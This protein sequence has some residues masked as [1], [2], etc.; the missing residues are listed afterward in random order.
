MMPPPETAA[1]RASQPADLPPR[2]ELA[3]VPFF[4][5]TPYQCGPAALATVLRSAGFDATPEQLAESVFLPSREG[6]LQTEMLAGARRSGAWALRLPPQLADV[7]REVQRGTP[8]IVLQNLGLSFAPRW[9]Y[10]VV[11][12]YDLERDEIVLRSGTTKRE[13]LGLATFEYTW[14]RGGRWAMVTARPGQLPATVLEADAVQGAIGLERVAPPAQS[15]AA[16]RSVLRRWP[17]NGVAAI[18][19]GN[20][21]QAAGDLEGAAGIF[22]HTALRSGSAVAWNNLAAVL[23]AQGHR[24]AAQRAARRAVESSQAHEPQWLPQARETLESTLR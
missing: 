23:L 20:A 4:P 5:Q 8:V 3:D 10:A 24:D 9:H 16:Y 18:G 21:L 6:S 7:L 1:L 17:G 13:V 2:A 22:E 12:G 11:V 15:A 19:L 14:A